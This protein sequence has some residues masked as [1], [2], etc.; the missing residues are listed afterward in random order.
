MARLPLT[1]ACGDYDRTH[2]LADGSVVPE[3]V[4]L[5]YI[6]LE[7]PGEIFWRQLRHEEFDASEL[8]LSAYV[9]TLSRG[10]RRFVAIPV[11]PLRTFRHSFIWVTERSGIKVPQDLV[12]K[13]IGIPEYHMTALLFIRGM[14]E[15]DYGV[16]PEDIHW[17]RGRVERIDLTLP[18]TI[19]LDDLPTGQTFGQM[20]E[21]GEL[22]GIAGT[23][24]PRSIKPNVAVRLFPRP[25][26]VEIDYYRRT[27]VFP[28][29]HVVAMRRE[30][31]EQHRW[32]AESLTKAFMEAKERAYHRMHEVSGLYSL[33][34]LNLD[35]EDT[36]EVFGD[37]PFTYGVDPNLPTL[38]AATE[39]SLEQGLSARKVEIEELFA[40][41]TLDV[42]VE[43]R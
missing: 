35:M 3:G 26:E 2:A 37:D 32:L 24:P 28:I 8:S 40:P 22:D 27:G 7:P 10:D 23:R 15:H 11:F 1:L 21:D 39:Y 36:R 25:R 4:D 5:N 43:A 29:M 41:E 30:L 31:Y 12:G 19:R 13:R 33:P 42:F 18:P 34:W 6:P 38:R 17:V 9:I 16:R 20:L 14:L